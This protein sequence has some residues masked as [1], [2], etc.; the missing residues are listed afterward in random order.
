MRIEAHRL[1]FIAAD[2]VAGLKTRPM[3]SVFSQK[4]HCAAPDPD[5]SK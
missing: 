4:Q 1:S 5:W 3:E 2:F